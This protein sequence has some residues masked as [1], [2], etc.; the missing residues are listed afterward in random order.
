MNMYPLLN[1]APLSGG[2]FL[3]WTLGANDAANCF[4]AAVAGH[5]VRFRQAALLCALGIIFG[6]V[7][8]GEQ[9]ICT[10]SGLTDQ[11]VATA[12][13]V[14]VAAGITGVLMTALGIPI[15]TSQA[16]VGAILGVGLALGRRDFDGLVKV[17]LCW[18]GTPLGAMLIAMLA[19]FPTGW[20]IERMRISILTRDK[21]LLSGLIIV[22]LYGSYALGAN[23]VT[24]ST[25][26]FSGLLPGVTDRTLALAGG[27]AMALGV[28]TF[29]KRVM[30]S[31]GG[32][33]TPLDAYSAFISVLAMSITV[34]I[35]AFLGAPVSTSQGIVGAVLGI[36][37]VRGV[38]S[39]QGRM[40]WHILLGWLLTP[41]LALMLAATAMAIYHGR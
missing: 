8:Q 37:M 34:H 4:G 11:T 33:I 24:N 35:F 39:I 18:L 2:L 19:Y 10:L 28:L 25:G 30:I 29:S 40:L 3:G 36:G 5:V 38:Q 1:S 13:I 31:V 20:L 16:V 17:V 7:L 32:R 9:G 41:L 22:G 23:N 14:T 15:S 21:L 26:V 6:A 12:V 27:V